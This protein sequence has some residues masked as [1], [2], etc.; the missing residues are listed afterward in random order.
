MSDM[1]IKK[2]IKYLRT[3]DKLG[4]FYP[5]KKATIK[6]YVEIDS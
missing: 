1:V 6:Y 5:K 4:L 3:P 2:N